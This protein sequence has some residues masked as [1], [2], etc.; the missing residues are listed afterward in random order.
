MVIQRY[1]DCFNTQPPEGGCNGN[2]SAAKA[3]GV[4]TRSR[5]KAAGKNASR[6]ARIYE[7]STRSRP[8]AAG[9]QCRIL[10][11]GRGFNTQPP[12][13]GCG[14]TYLE[15]LHS[16]VSTRSRPKAAGV[17]PACSCT[18][19][20]FNTQ[21]PEGGCSAKI[22]PFSRASGFNTQPPEG[23]CDTMLGVISLSWV[24]TRSRPKAAGKAVKGGSF[25]KT[26]QHAA[27]RRR[28]FLRFCVIWCNNLVS[29]R[30]RPKAAA[31][32]TAITGLTA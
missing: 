13:G 18:A 12:E 8:K 6:F 31:I 24:S 32:R 16:V 2:G 22:T 1:N 11:G 7:V 29:T 19:N 21:P 4:S 14:N 28:L 10:R 15:T 5:P 20:S 30:S 17:K 26:F 27:A 9:H 23:G 3:S 25:V